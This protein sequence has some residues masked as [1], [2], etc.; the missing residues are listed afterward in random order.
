MAHVV[1]ELAPGAPF[2]VGH[3]AAHLMTGSPHHLGVV[4]NRLQVV[5]GVAICE[6]VI[7]EE[8]RLNCEEP[9][10]KNTYLRIYR[11]ST[12]KTWPEYLMVISEFVICLHKTF[13]ET[14]S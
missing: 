3:P 9:G 14:H 11:H 2:A 8:P 6:V 1:I 5:R 7:L 13:Y 12:E 10:K 4:A